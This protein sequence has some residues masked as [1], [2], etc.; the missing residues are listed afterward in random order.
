LKQQGQLEVLKSLCKSS[1]LIIENFTVGTM[2]RLGLGSKELI[3]LNPSLV[4][5]SMS[6]PGRS[7]SLERLRSYGLVLSAL[8]GA[9]ASITE[10][11]QFLGS[12]TF[13]ISDPNAAVFATIGALAGA[14]R[15][16]ET[17][18][19]SIIDLSQIEAVAALN[20]TPT[21]PQTNLETILETK[22]GYYVAIS[23]P[24][25]AF[26][27]QRLPKEELAKLTKVSLI[28]KCKDLGGEIC[29]LIELSESGDRA[30]FKECEGHVSVT[31]PYTGS[32][33]IVAAPW[34]INGKRPIPHKAAPVLGENNSY[35]LRSILNL[36]DAQLTELG[37]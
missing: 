31:H 7:S 6:G 3:K 22:D 29:D 2:D 5:I 24:K 16:Q 18:T 15:A 30:V 20:V 21:Q 33:K 19:G 13:S 25:T 26:T 14:I 4:Q 27:D 12:P 37:L 9:E 23:V 35:V 34:R 36:S 10:D 1:D 11:N 28:K 17:G 8:G 32:K